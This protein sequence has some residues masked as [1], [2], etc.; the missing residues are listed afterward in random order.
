MY[1]LLLKTKDSKSSIECYPLFSMLLAIGQTQ[2][3]FLS[4]GKLMMNYSISMISFIWTLL[5][6]E[7][8]EESILKAIPWN[9]IHIELV[10]IEVNH[11]DEKEIRRIMKDAGYE[12]YMEIQ[13]RGIS[14]HYTYIRLIKLVLNEF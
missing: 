13:E 5:D 10:T 9:K 6:V 14:L 7:G 2:I 8:A 3:D 4:L 1:F 11:S 12:V